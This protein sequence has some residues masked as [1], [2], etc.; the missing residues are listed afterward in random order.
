MKKL[1]IVSSF[2]VL[3]LSACSNDNVE[4]YYSTKECDTENVTYSG[5]INPVIDRNC[6][7]CHYSGNGSGVT[8]ESYTDIKTNIDNGRITGA[9]KH[10][11]GFSPMPQGGKLDD[12]TIAKI[13]A[14][15]NN[16]ALNN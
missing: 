13:E 9:I 12:C 16:G 1:F 4:E 7:S 2:T 5:T 11:P 3:I 14:W 8:L 10:M 6:K 15:I